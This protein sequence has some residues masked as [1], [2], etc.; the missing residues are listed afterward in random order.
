MISCFSPVFELQWTMTLAHGAQYA[1]ST[2]DSIV[3]EQ[4]EENTLK[5]LVKKIDLNRRSNKQE[6]PVWPV[7][8]SV[9]AVTIATIPYQGWVLANFES[10]LAR[11]SMIAVGITPPML[12]LCLL[13]YFIIEKRRKTESE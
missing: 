2:G 6:R 5:Q 11:I 10:F 1:A 12:T 3:A 4:L 8:I 9:A 13:M 7:C